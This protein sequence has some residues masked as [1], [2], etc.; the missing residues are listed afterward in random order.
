MRQELRTTRPDR[1]V[2]TIDDIVAIES[3]PYD[4]LV[5]AHNLYDL[6]RATARHVPERRAL[7]VLRSENPYDVGASLTHRELLGE[8]TRAANLFR[9]LGITPQRGVVAFLA[10]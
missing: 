9:A 1:R 4:E 6:F 10:P 5:T 2:L 8:I 3:H 7:T